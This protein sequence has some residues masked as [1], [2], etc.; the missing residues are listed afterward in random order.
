MFQSTN[1]DKAKNIIEQMGKAK[2]QRVKYLHSQ[3]NET[4]ISSHQFAVSNN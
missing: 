3:T 2:D 1:L 4:T